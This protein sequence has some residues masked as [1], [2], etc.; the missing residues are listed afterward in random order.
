MEQP[1][2][3]IN[4]VVDINDEGELV[5][6]F[7]YNRRPWTVNS[8]RSGNRW[9]RAKNTKEWRQAYRDA[10][11]DHGCH[12][13]TQARISVFLEMKGRLQDTGACMPA[14]KAA[15]D[16]MVDAGLFLDDTGEHVES[17]EFH[18]PERAKTDYITLIVTGYPIEAT[19][20]EW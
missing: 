12:Q 10:I 6:S 15:V 4:I 11:L 20:A 18:A 8:E 1:D 13:L 16:G 2:R 7:H 17:I 9:T 19:T 14:V 3:P 5:Y